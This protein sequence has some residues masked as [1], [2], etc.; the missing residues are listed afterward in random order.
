MH[1]P[2]CSGMLRNQCADAPLLEQ[3]PQFQGDGMQGKRRPILLVMGILILL[4]G[5]ALA[6]GG[7]WLI[8]LGGSWYYAI[9]A[10]ALL[11]TGFLL[12]AGRPSA[13]WVYALLVAGTLAWSLW[14]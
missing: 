10:A 9:A 3:C 6:V 14:E 11:S 5:L 4:M 8:A 13:L 2:K 7:V 12:I 1:P